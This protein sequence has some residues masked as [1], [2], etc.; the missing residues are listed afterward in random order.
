MDPLGFGL[1]NFDAVGAWRTH[2]GAQPIDSS[3]KLPGGKP[4]SGA[5]ELKAALK[6]RPNAFAHCL[7]EKMLTFALGRAL[8]GTDRRALEQIVDRLAAGDYRF[9]TL[10]LAIVESEP[11]GRRVEYGGQR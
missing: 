2:D 5:T 9:H 7:A 3:G 1:E 6:S 11:F 8:S 4:F 10:V